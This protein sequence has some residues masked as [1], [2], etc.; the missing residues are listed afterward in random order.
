M[1]DPTDHAVLP[2]SEGFFSSINVRA[3]FSAAAIVTASPALPLP[4]TMTS[5]EVYDITQFFLGQSGRK[6]DP[7]RHFVTL[8][9]RSG[10]FEYLDSEGKIRKPHSHRLEQSDINTVGPDLI[11]GDD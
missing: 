9:M 6:F 10:T 5:L 11:C 1:I 8:V 4:T 7:V 2:L 3:P